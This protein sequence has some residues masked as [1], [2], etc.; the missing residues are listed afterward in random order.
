MK[1]YQRYHL[2]TCKLS[3][4][5]A[6]FQCNFGVESYYQ[7]ATAACVYTVPVY[8][9]TIITINLLWNHSTTQ[10]ISVITSFGCS[11]N[12]RWTRRTRIFPRA[13]HSG[14]RVALAN[15]TPYVGVETTRE[16]GRKVPACNPWVPLHQLLD[17]G[18]ILVDRLQ[19][20]CQTPVSNRHRC[21]NV[22]SVWLQGV[23]WGIHH[24]VSSCSF[25]W[26]A[27]FDIQNSILSRQY[28]I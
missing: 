18:Q 26:Q 25:V 23:E 22:R 3:R 4:L 7:F 6:W 21:H 12:V 2:N 27:V 10:P 16:G 5:I 1:C 17:W 19:C 20:H 15:P 8:N 24:M 28:A 13:L 11:G 9:P 14:P